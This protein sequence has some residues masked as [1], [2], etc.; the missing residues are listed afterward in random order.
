MSLLPAVHLRHTAPDPRSR[1]R[2]AVALRHAASGVWFGLPTLLVAG[3]AITAAVGAPLAVGGGLTPWTLLV[4]AVLAGPLV[5]ATAATANQLVVSTETGVSAWFIDVRT[6][7]GRGVRVW[8][9]PAI[10]GCLLLFAWFVLGRT[11]SATAVISAAVCAVVTAITI[12]GALAASVVWPARPEL[13]WAQVWLT[14]G[15]L[16]ARWPVRFLAPM[17][18]LGLG[19]WAGLSVTG[20]LL[21]LVPGPVLMLTAAAFWSSAVECG[22]SE[23]DSE[24]ERNHL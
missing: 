22:A 17:C 13:S 11:G 19:L 16:A 4:I 3:V 23:L 15:H 8:L 21:V 6:L 7:A 14:A 18:L 10:P 12:T 5:L 9:T 24:P 2:Q 1:A 20:T